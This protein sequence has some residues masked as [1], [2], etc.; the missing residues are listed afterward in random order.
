A[1]NQ[2]A[3]I[4]AACDRADLVVVSI[5]VHMRNCRSGAIL[6]TARSLRR[7][8]S[9]AIAVG[10]SGPVDAAPGPAPAGSSARPNFRIRAAL[11][12]VIRPWTVQ[13]YYDWRTGRYDLPG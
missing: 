2:A 5:P 11:E 8:G 12:G 10:G 4:G 3:L 1:I 7:S 9:L 13:R 6:V